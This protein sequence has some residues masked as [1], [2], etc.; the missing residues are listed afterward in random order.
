MR[1]KTTSAARQRNRSGVTLTE[2]LMSM[3]IM[4]IG[5]S[6]VMV[7]FPIAALRSAQA[8]KMTN[9]A[10]VK[11]NVEAMIR[12]RPEIIFD[13][14]GDFVY[15]TADSP[16]Y[17]QRLTEHFRS[18]SEKRYVIDP[19]GYFSAAATYGSYGTVNRSVNGSTVDV[20]AVPPSSRR[21]SDYL[22]NTAAGA[23]TGT[24]YTSLPRYDGGLR[25]GGLPG[26]NLD[27]TPSLTTDFEILGSNMSNLGDGWDTVADEIAEGV[28]LSDGSFSPSTSAAPNGSVVGVRLD[29]ELDLS[30]V[31][32]SAAYSAIL[33]I[34]DPE[35]TRITI[36]S[37]DGRMSQT[38]PL[39]AISA[40]DCVWT[41]TAVGSLA[42]TDYN[43]D[44]IVSMRRLPSEFGNQVGRVVIQ[45]KRT[46]DFNWLITVRRGS[47]GRAVGV[48]IVVLFNDG[49][50]PESERVYP[51]T[52][53]A[54]SFGMIV[55]KTSGVD[56][57]GD[58]AEPHLKRGGY[59][60][61]VENARW[62]RIAKFE[63]N[64]ADAT[65]STYLVTLEITALENSPNG[66]GGAIFLPGIVDVYPLGS[67]PL[68]ASMTPQTF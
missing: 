17:W 67:V 32:S 58:P 20:N 46:Q 64:T 66:G 50:K 6:S 4:A 40:S 49:R 57:D 60:L 8:T 26:L 65:N 28:V 31:V 52:F 11:Y 61:D 3:M 48:D 22:G 62:Y 7:L 51:A 47:D 12:A 55:K 33:S 35:L 34:P 53:I 44:Q 30:V 16:K 27:T 37:V 24:P 59:V 43:Q 36:F 14:D 41:E 39:T 63:D 19:Y 38:Y 5:V 1:R 21:Y 23:T 2:V 45:K 9:G 54:G 68:P 13:P 15:S 25:S 29:S 18:N 10:I 42:A 56:M